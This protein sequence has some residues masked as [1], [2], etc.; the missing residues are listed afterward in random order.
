[1]KTFGPSAAGDKMVMQML[2]CSMR[3]IAKKAKEMGSNMNMS[4]SADSPSPSG[5]EDSQK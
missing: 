2:N 4:T 5:S 1:M 3:Y